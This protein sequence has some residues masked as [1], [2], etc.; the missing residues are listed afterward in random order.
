MRKIDHISETINGTEYT[1]KVYRDTEWNEYICRL[2]IDGIEH[3]DSSYHTDDKEDALASAYNL[4][5]MTA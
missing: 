3:K 5:F 2:F 4:P 1:V